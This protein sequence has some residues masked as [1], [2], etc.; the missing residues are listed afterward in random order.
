[1]PSAKQIAWRKKFAKLYGKKKTGKKSTKAKTREPRSIAEIQRQMKKT[2]YT[3]SW[4]RDHKIYVKRFLAKYN[5]EFKK[6]S[7]ASK[8]SFMRDHPKFVV[9]I[10]EAH[11]A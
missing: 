9:R 7:D 10:L 2:K 6:M 3:P 8:K 5:A 11:K 4:I 1:M